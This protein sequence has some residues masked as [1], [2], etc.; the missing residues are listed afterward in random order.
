MTRMI[1]AVSDHDLVLPSDR[2][3]GDAG[4]L[5]EWAGD[6]DYDDIDGAV[7]SFDAFS[8]KRSGAQELIGLMR[9]Q[10]PGLQVYGLSLSRRHRKTWSPR[11]W[12][13]SPADFRTTCWLRRV[14]EMSLFLLQIRNRIQ[15]LKLNSKL[16]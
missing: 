16:R 12:N 6:L 2:L 5:L 8:Q 3:I 4:K 15:S 1:A 7:I 9:G 13:R 11:F 10:R 14:R